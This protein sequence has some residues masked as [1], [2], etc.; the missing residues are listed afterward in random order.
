MEVSKSV[1]LPAGTR[2]DGNVQCPAGTVMLTGGANANPGSPP[3]WID[4]SF[5]L[6]NGWYARAFNSQS[7]SGNLLIFA[8]CLQ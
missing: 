4:A 1:D 7:F 2:R 8:N 6:N 5:P 3:P